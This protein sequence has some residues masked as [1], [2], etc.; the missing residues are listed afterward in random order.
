MY[1]KLEMRIDDEVIGLPETYASAFI[2]SAD[3]SIFRSRSQGWIDKPFPTP[4]NIADIFHEMLDEFLPRKS[5]PDK[6][7]EE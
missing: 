1:Y 7:E 6:E 2:G 5:A 4:E 3:G